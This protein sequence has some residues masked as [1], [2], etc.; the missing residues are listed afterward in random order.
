MAEF[1]T[2]MKNKGQYRIDLP[3]KKIALVAEQEIYVRCNLPIDDPIE[4]LAMKGQETPYFHDRR[5]AFCPVSHRTARCQSGDD[6][7][8]F[9]QY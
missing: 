8:D 2:G 4:T 3:D 5:L 6:G 7:A 1:L 9:C